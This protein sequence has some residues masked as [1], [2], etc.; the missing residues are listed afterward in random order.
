MKPKLTEKIRTEFNRLREK[1]SLY[2]VKGN[3]DVAKRA[4]SKILVS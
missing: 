2:P 1:G 4:I 3:Y